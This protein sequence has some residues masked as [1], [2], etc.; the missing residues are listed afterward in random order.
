MAVEPVRDQLLA[1]HRSTIAS[2]LDAADRVADDRDEAE[3]SESPADPLERELADRGLL[4]RLLPVVE[5][6]ADAAGVELQAPPVAAP[7][8]LAVTG[9]GPV[10]RATGPDRRVV[11]EIVAFTIERGESGPRYRRAASDPMR[12]LTVSIRS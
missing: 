12:A 4:D 2:V 10:L 9:R 5:T 7:P 3:A 11:V 1:E 6:A 8:Y